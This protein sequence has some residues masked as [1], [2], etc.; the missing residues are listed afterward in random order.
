M[1]GRGR[2]DT[3]GRIALG[4]CAAACLT[5]VGPAAA[6][7]ASRY[8]TPT[9]TGTACTQAAPCS[10]TTAINAAMSGD[11]VFLDGSLGPYNLG[12]LIDDNT[13]E[14]HVQGINGRPRL[15]F[16]TANGLLLLNSAS[17]AEN[18]YVESTDASGVA[19]AFSIP[20]GG[21]ANNIIARSAG[22]NRACF[23]RNATLTN[24][25]CWAPGAGGVGLGIQANLGNTSDNLA[26]L[27]I[28]AGPSGEAV[29][30]A[31]I[32]AN[33][34]LLT[35]NSV[36]ARSG[37]GGNDLVAST[38]N[39][40]GEASI[41]TIYT[42]Y[43]PATDSLSGPGLESINFDSSD[44]TD[45]PV[46]VNA[47]AG[48][49]H[50]LLASPTIDAGDPSAPLPADLDFDGEQR[51][52]APNCFGGTAVRDIGADELVPDCL[53]PATRLNRAPRRRTHRRRVKF[54]FSSNEPG[55]TFKCKLD[56]RP[57]RPCTSP[58][59]Y[60]VRPGKHV[61]KVKATD[62]AGNTDPTPAQKRFRVLP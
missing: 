36:I 45:A 35:L 40:G 53:A 62:A 26:N 37:A 54:K 3:P 7:A 47:A 6:G 10:A 5:L 9:G 48:D 15:I 56:H 21:S 11:N 22:F 13:V 1:T 57:F 24:S 20:N 60:R 34:A 23:Q 31:S 50:Q 12:A 30:V 19:A 42:N 16:S 2:G 27:T 39:A 41:S 51:A 55:S 58:K 4:L 14:V 49:F 46:F 59:R 33:Q 52:A 32:G 38:D 44:V 8:A 61:F 25:V 17:T 18:L 28:V 29:S 43:D